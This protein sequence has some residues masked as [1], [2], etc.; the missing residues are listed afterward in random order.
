MKN[1]LVKLAIL[2]MSVT[3]AACSTNTQQENTGIGAVT[4]A[5]IGGVA[6]SAIGAGTGQ[7]V[8]IGA[9]AVIGAL[10]GGAV[11]HSMESSDTTQT[12]VVL[13][14]NPTNRAT[15]WT[16]TRTGATYTVVPTSGNM[17]MKGYAVCRKFRATVMM[18]GKKEHVYGVACRQTDG[19]WRAV[20]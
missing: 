7:V 4:G 19:T 15:H 1:M 17:A 8:A 10:V 2:L 6:G 20:R 16:N 12:Y 14:K 3:L 18:H 9:G 13:E 5:V 11:G